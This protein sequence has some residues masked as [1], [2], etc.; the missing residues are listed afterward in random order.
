M[1][2]Q[3]SEVANLQAAVMGA[4]KDT[5]FSGDQ[6]DESYPEGYQDHFWHVARIRVVLNALR[7]HVPKSSVVLEIGCARG[8]YVAKAREAGFAAFGCDLGKPK[9]HDVVSDYVRTGTDFRDLDPAVLAKVS[10]VLLFDVLEHLDEPKDVLA[11]LSVAMPSLRTVI[12][13]VPARRELWSNYDD[14][15]GHFRRYTRL[16]LENLFNSAGFKSVESR[17]FFRFLYPPMWI[18]SNIN[19]S[20]AVAIQRPGNRWLHKV[21]GVVGILDAWLLPKNVWGT[22]VIGV[23][24]KG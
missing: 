14:H 10:A 7:R 16:D 2:N 21:I 23:A 13:T 4:E 24:K 3:G 1:T 22:S 9:V 15:F 8:L 19:R 6:Y 17:Y 12:A 20:R 18:L 5:A 11:Q